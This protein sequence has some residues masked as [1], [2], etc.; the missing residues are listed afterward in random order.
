VEKRVDPSRHRWRHCPP[1]TTGAPSGDGAQS[2]YGNLAGFGDRRNPIGQTERRG[3]TERPVVPETSRRRERGQRNG[4]ES[5]GH[6]RNSDRSPLPRR[7][8]LLPES[9]AGLPELPEEFWRTLDSG[10]GEIGLELNEPARAA[11]DAHVRLLLAWNEAIN[12]TALRTPEQIARN[13]VLDSLVAVAA[14]RS[15]A[16]PGRAPDRPAH[17]IDLGSGGGFP[18][19]PLASVLPIRKVVLVDSIGKK[20]RFL[21][22]AA[23]AV[24]EALSTSGA[25]PPEIVAV[26][27]R[28]EDLAGEPE[29]RGGADL[30]LARAVGSVAEVAELGLPLARVRGSVVIWKRDPGDGALEAEMEAA[31]RISQACGGATPRVVGLPA[32][33]RIGLTGHCLVVIGKRRPTPERYPRSASE[34]RHVPLLS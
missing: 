4:S 9:P 15:L 21:G 29:Y 16:S 1:C 25:E 33:D 12:L 30:I 10:L 11:I 5:F 13:H 32:A 31:R 2:E 27:E 20:A 3:K 28:A 18:G 19:L 17:L 34:R 22:V 6:G 23:A 8:P 7:F 24:S 26:P 14:L